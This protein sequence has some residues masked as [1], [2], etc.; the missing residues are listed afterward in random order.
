MKREV[1]GLKEKHVPR[2]P[3]D[4]ASDQP[5]SRTQYAIDIVTASSF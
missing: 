3:C 5:G 1:V 2:P 4:V